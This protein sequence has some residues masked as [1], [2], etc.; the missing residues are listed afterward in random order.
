MIFTV[1]QVAPRCL[2]VGHFSVVGHAGLNRRRFSSRMHGQPLAPGTYRI[3][4][5][6]ASGRLVRRVTLVVVSGSAPTPDELLAA[7]AANTCS[8]APRSTAAT[9]SSAAAG[10]TSLPSQ[11]FPP[12]LD[13]QSGQAGGLP[14]PRG[15]NPNAGVLAQSIQKTARA[16]RP[17]LVALLALAIALLGMAALP[18]VAVPDSRVNYL[19]ARHRVELAG[20]GVAA[21]VA[22]AIALLL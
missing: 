15:G 5:R 7:R 17:Y 14:S 19:L 3:A 20:L 4:A 16:V 2:G 6:T 1:N 11:S 12:P 22:V 9:G 18:R 10:P 21:L 13:R 8:A